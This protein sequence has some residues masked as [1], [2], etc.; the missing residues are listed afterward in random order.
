MSLRES[1]A[2]TTHLTRRQSRELEGSSRAVAPTTKRGTPKQ[3]QKPGKKARVPRSLRTPRPTKRP[4][5]IARKLLS[6]GAVLFAGALVVGMSVPAN[7]FMP[8]DTFSADAVTVAS[9]T[10]AA[11]KAPVQSERISADAAPITVARDTFNVTSYAELLRAQYGSQ[12]GSFTA[13]TGAI[14]WPFPYTV[15]ITDGF[16]WRPN[17]TSGT[18]HH[19][20]VDFTPGNGTPIYAIADGVVTTHSDDQ[21]GYGNHVI[22]SHNINGEAFDSLYAHMQTGT[23]PLLVGDQIKVG[24]FIGLVGD[25]GQSYGAH[26]PFEVRISQVPVDPFAWLQAHATN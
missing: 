1:D 3:A 23:S 7:L 12:G 20:G 11:T 9:S 10:T 16:G 26:L 2:A 8:A 15:P 13:T 17:G 25:T 21:Y 18:S 22:I 5:K 4:R 24:D 14:R 19:N 6:F